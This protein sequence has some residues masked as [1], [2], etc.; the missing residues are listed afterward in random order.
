MLNAERYKESIK[1]LGYS[2]ALCKGEIE[3]CQRADCENC[4]FGSNSGC[5]SKKIKWLLKE[6]REPIL[7]DEA[8]A[9]LKA[10]I[11]PFSQVYKICR[12]HGEKVDTWKLRFFTNNG[13]VFISY[14]SNTEIYEF[15]KYMKI[16]KGYDPEELGLC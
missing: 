11:E 15:F 10:I 2:F 5:T 12:C 13:D 9:Y 1:V 6:Y 8:K 3:D 14:N 7:S 16:G 4:E